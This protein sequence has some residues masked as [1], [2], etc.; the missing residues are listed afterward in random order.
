[1]V[2]TPELS[3]PHENTQVGHDI[4]MIGDTVSNFR[5]LPCILPTQTPA[6]Q[7]QDI[8]DHT[9]VQQAPTAAAYS[10]WY[11]W[12]RERALGRAVWSNHVDR[13]LGGEHVVGGLAELSQR[14][15]LRRVAVQQR[16]DRLPEQPQP[17]PCRRR[18]LREV[19][20]PRELLPAQ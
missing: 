3:R 18:L 13:C 8:Y 2:N 16:Q 5:G 1:M 6:C 4:M 19:A 10:T 17:P 11:V 9:N 15:A 12:S 14:G 7:R 20:L